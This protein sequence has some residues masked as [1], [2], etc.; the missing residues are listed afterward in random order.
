MKKGRK[1]GIP[2]V[3]VVDTNSSPDGIDMPIPGNDDATRAIALYCQLF[4]DAVLDGIQAEV[5][6]SGGDLG[7]AAEVPVEAVVAEAPAADAP[8]AAPAAA[9]ETP[10]S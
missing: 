3:A 7:A 10:A 5:T 8:S 4:S 2:I 1:L 9:A 6:A